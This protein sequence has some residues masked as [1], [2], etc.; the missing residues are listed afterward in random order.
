M[1]QNENVVIIG[2]GVI[3][4]DMA[5]HLGALDANGSTVAVLA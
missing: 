2:G 1:K 5:A 4:V 3:G